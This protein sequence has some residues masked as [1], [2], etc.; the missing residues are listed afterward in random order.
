VPAG[1]SDESEAFGYWQMENYFK[2][3]SALAPGSTIPDL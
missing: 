1:F 3:V 2:I